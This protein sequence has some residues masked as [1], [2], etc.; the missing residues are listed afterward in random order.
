[1]SISKEE[2][3]QV[4]L[5]KLKKRYPNRYFLNKKVSN[6]LYEKLKRYPKNTAILFYIPLGLEVDV[7][8]VLKKLRKNY[9]IFVPFMEGKS[10]KMVPYRLPLKRKKFGI[11]EAGNS[12]KRI[13][14]IDIAIVPIIGIDKN[15]KRIGFGKGMYDRFFEKLPHK[16]YTIFLQLKRCFIDETICDSYDISCDMLITSDCVLEREG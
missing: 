16:P 8:W 2:F 13:K 3:R 11:Y 12:F 4:C 5:K 7:G 10:F 6:I 1:M 14:N 9:Q 15:Y